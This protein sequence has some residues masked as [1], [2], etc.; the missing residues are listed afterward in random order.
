MADLT[1]EYFD[2]QLK[3]LATKQDI[4]HL[5]KKIDNLKVYL[6]SHIENKI[7]ELAIA[8]NVGFEDVIK[9][10]DVRER[11]EKLE[12]KMGKMEKALNLRL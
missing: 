9:K 11:V 8:V 7:G 10:L 4:N 5:D 6:E 2:K 1:K 12:Q 3:N